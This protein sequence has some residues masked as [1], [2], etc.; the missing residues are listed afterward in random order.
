MNNGS[1]MSPTRRG[2]RQNLHPLQILFESIWKKSI[3]SMLVA[4]QQGAFPFYVLTPKS[5]SPNALPSN[6]IHAPVDGSQKYMS[7][8]TN[9][10]KT[11]SRNLS[12]KDTDKVSL[13]EFSDLCSC[14]YFRCICTCYHNYNTKVFYAVVCNSIQSALCIGKCLIAPILL[15][16]DCNLAVDATQRTRQWVFVQDA[17]QMLLDWL[18]ATVAHLC[19]ITLTKHTL[20]SGL[21]LSTCLHPGTR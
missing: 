3:Q 10:R 8:K 7:A 19:S 1:G 17:H 13:K 9:V 15:V 4:H 21:S 2:R 11:T 14:R 5:L 12:S 16:M 6:K 18:L 20:T